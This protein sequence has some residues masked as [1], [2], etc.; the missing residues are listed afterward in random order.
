MAANL[1]MF[2]PAAEPTRP[3][4]QPI[5]TVWF[6]VS[7]LMLLPQGFM[8][9]I[10]RTV[11]KIFALWEQRPWTNVRF[12]AI[13]PD[14]GIAEVDPA[15]ILPEMPRPKPAAPPAPMPA[16]AAF[17]AP[18]PKRSRY[19]YLPWGVRRQV[20]K[21]GRKVKH[22]W[23]DPAVL[24]PPPA[25]VP[26]PPP[27]APPRPHHAPYPPESLVRMLDLGPR[28]LV[29]SLGGLWMVP[30]VN[31]TLRTIKQ[32]QKFQFC[33]LIYDIIPLFAPHCCSPALV[34]S[35]FKPSTD[36]QLKES[37]LLLT[38]SNYS[39]QDI[40][41]YAEQEY[42]PIAPVEVFT[43]GSDI[44]PM[45]AAL[46][47]GT[48]KQ[49]PRPYVLTVGSVEVR[50]NHYGMYQA[51]R[52]LVKDHG[53]DNVPDL[54]VAGKPAWH[55]DSILYLMQ[56]DPLVKHKIVVKDAPSDRELDWLYKNCLFT[57]YP[58]FYEGW[59]LPVEESLIYGKVCVTTNASSLPEVGRDFAEYIEPEDTDAIVRAVRKCLDENYRRTREAYIREKFRP[60][61]WDDSSL[62]LQSVLRGYYQFPEDRAQPAPPPAAPV[63]PPRSA[64]LLR[65]FGRRAASV[66]PFLG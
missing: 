32:R 11:S 66:L 51:W 3:P 47:A 23:V 43:L 20:R 65:R 57:L 25:P 55:G 28:D 54:V 21:A 42:M 63:V 62:Q 2:N 9:G 56:N 41:K 12:C 6:D 4:V 33:S 26:P 48:P 39:K 5:D 60:T 17:V 35:T 18:P 44:K 27:P 58:S 22:F 46:S 15:Y 45:D 52:R 37:D 49:H 13:V 24:Y 64:S 59:G 7:V 29:F 1:K 31:K 8:S 36:V 19:W 10:P 50:K 40:L 38:I 16:A 34:L 30:N 14:L 53:P 61:T